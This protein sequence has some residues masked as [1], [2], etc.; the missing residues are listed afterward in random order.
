MEEELAILPW[1]LRYFILLFT[2]MIIASSHWQCIMVQ[3]KMADY[4]NISIWK[5]LKNYD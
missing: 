1:L 4:T 2:A 5:E 3:E